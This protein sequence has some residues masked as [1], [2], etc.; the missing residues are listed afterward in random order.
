MEAFSEGEPPTT[1]EMGFE[2]R[3]KVAGETLVSVM[4]PSRRSQTCCSRQHLVR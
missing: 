1:E 3:P 2:G 4:R